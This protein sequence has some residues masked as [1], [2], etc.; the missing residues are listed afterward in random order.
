MKSNR[1]NKCKSPLKAIREMCIQCMGAT[2]NYSKLIKE[3][4]SPNCPIFIYRFGKNPHHSKNISD[5]QRKELAGRF[6]STG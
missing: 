5:E 3:C 4:A 1:S 6:K 2:Q